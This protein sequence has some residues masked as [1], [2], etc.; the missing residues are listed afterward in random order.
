MK[1]IIALLI[2]FSF[3]NLLS[4]D[5]KCLNSEFYN[6]DYDVMQVQNSSDSINEIIKSELK[7]DS[8]RLVV[9][10]N[11]Y[12][13]FPKWASYKRKGIDSGFKIILINNSS[14]DFSLFNMDGRIIMKRQF[15][16]KNKWENVKSYD[17]TPQ[18]I[19]GNSYFT[20]RV[21]K[22]RDFFTFIAPCVEGDI[23]AKF[24][25][26]VYVNSE[27]EK[28]TVYSNEFDG[29]INKKLIE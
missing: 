16:Y 14:N 3:G 13:K 28:P 11:S 27:T 19:C 15:Y 22:S 24:R 29:F 9:I 17:R 18:P 5:L 26:V 25:F 21:I 2:L 1:K 12:L 23:K 10:P 6:S 4:Q 8:L 7:S 20:K